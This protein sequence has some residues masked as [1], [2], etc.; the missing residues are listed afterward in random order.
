[1]QGGGP[2]ADVAFILIHAGMLVRRFV[3]TKARQNRSP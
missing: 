2:A 1:L 3:H